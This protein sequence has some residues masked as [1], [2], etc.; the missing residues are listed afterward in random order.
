MDKEVVYNGILLSHKKERN[1]ITCDSMD[2]IGDYYANL[3][4][5]GNEK[6]ILYD[7]TYNW[8]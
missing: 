1:L 7:L 6:Q 2:V 3:N 8:N 4:K 5:P